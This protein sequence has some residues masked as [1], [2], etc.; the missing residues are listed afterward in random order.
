MVDSRRSTNAPVMRKNYHASR[1]GRG[2]RRIALAA[3]SLAIAGLL[4]IVLLPADRTSATATREGGNCSDCHDGGQT[5]SMMSVTGLP[6]GTFT[7]GQQY[8]VTVSITDT[9]SG[10]TG[11]NSFD[12]LATAGSI[13]TS[14]ANV[15]VN[16]P[17]SG[18]SAEA[19]AN[20]A[21]ADMTAT[22]FTLVW[23]APV[24][25]DATI[26]VWAVMGD[27]AGGT[28]DIWDHE[29]YNYAAIPEFPAV[30]VPVLGIAAALVAAFRLSGRKN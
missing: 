2:R 11:E 28:V 19:S 6:V 14:D 9:N 3:A 23:T 7:P 1:V 5:T 25:G 8:T 18:Y 16:T 22:T 4:A 29:S 24:S 20:D 27:G 17:T 15:E 12:F 21:V 13:T 26:E 10:S 30:L